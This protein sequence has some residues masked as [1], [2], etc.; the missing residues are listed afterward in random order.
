MAATKVIVAPNSPSALANPRTAAAVRPGAASGTMMRTKRTREDA[1][2]VRAASSDL[3][4]DGFYGLP[5]GPHHQGKGHDAGRQGR[6]GPAEGEHHAHRL[7]RLAQDSLAAQQHQ[8]GEARGHGRQDEGQ[9]DDGVE[10]RAAGE[11][12]AR[13]QISHRQGGRQAAEGGGEG[14]LQGQQRRDQVVARQK[15][16]ASGAGASRS[17]VAPASARRSASASSM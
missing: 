11:P 5:D 4:I 3:G 17:T 10:Q 8:Q 12:P 2:R 1:P 6:A 9:V 14:H 15:A 13:Q 7:Q 16:H